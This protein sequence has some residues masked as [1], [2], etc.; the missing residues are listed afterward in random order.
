MR[1]R[2]L[3]G[4]ATSAMLASGCAQSDA[5]ITTSVKSRLAADDLVQARRID[6]DTRDRVVTL[7]GE[8]RST[9]EEAKALQIAGATDGVSN[10]VD[11]LTVVPE[12]QPAPTTGVAP[13]E[14]GAGPLTSDASIT[15]EVKAK[16]LADPDTS[17]L[18][19]DVDTNNRIVTLTGTVKTQAE[20]TE[21]VEIARKVGGVTNVNDR[22]T[23]ER[24]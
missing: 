21:A 13:S 11:E 2:W 7:T 5:G 6:V 10:V 22:L 15:T 14:P 4:I 9:E 24:R 17:G 18:R 19:I 8:V 12:P 3:F 16:L 1:S 23:V 20:K